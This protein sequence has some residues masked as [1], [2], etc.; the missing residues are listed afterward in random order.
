MR[1]REYPDK[2]YIKEY[3]YVTLLGFIFCFLISIITYDP[4][5]QTTFNISSSAE[6]VYS[7]T[8]GPI[9]AC[10]ADWS[11][12][13]F[14]IGA[15]LFSCVFFIQIFGFFRKPSMQKR[16]FLRLFGYPQ[17]IICYLGLVQSIDPV[18]H[19]R[20]IEIAS[21][22]W[23]GQFVFFHLKLVLGAY[24]AGIVCAFGSFS[25]LTLCLGI[26]PISTVFSLIRWLPFKKIKLFQ[27][28]LKQPDEFGV[29]EIPK[30]IT[31]QDANDP[32]V[33]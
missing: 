23:I 3:L 12:Q 6:P 16:F 4:A 20:G 21:G 19:F 2:G 33:G 24:G 22:G 18:V 14:G 1:Q 28:A 15:I 13:V 8:F 5:D 30:D 26:R 10:I 25:S 9:G 29:V 27:E 11:F 31:K 32:A 17:L 7:N